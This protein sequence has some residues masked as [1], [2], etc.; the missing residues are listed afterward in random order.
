MTND[1]RFTRWFSEIGVADVSLVGGKN[2]SLGE[3]YREPEGQGIRVPN[4]FAVTA[5]AYRYALAQG[6]AWLRL[7]AALDGLNPSDVDNLMR[8]TGLAREIVYCAG[9]P[10]DLAT[11]ILDAYSALADQYG[12][13]L[14]VAVR[15]SAMAG[16]LP[17]ASFA[18]RHET[19][20]SIAGEAKVLEVRAGVATQ[21]CSRSG[22]SCTA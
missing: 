20:L 22:P 17:T 10:P 4:G 13:H 21:A 7:Q 9:L 5:E 12:E 1:N 3:T 16:Y 8:R 15:S 14:A 18:G 19:F 11:Q 2:A 6:D